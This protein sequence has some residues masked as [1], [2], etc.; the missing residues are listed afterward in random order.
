MEMVPHWHCTDGTRSVVVAAATRE[1][2]REVGRRRLGVEVL[3]KYLSNGGV[4][5]PGEVGHE[6]KRY[7]KHSY[8]GGRS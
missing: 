4:P 5:A 3:V 1:E 8:T 2:A 7:Q 6:S